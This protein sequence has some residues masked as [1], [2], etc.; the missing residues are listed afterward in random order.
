[1]KKVSKIPKIYK[2]RAYHVAN[3][4]LTISGVKGAIKTGV[5][6]TAKVVATN[7]TAKKIAAEQ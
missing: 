7:A 6:V 3:I 5:K 1:M 4:S 2:E